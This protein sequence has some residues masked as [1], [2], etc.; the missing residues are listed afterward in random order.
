MFFS[1]DRRSAVSN[2][3]LITS[4]WNFPE[5]CQISLLSTWF[6]PMIFPCF[7]LIFPI[8]FPIFSSIFHHF[9]PS[10]HGSTSPLSWSPG[11]AALHADPAAAAQR[12]RPG[13]AGGGGD[14]ACLGDLKKVELVVYGR[15]TIWLWLRVC[16]GSHHHAKKR[17]VN[18][19]YWLGPSKPWQT[20]K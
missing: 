4:K 13:G 15:F 1:V 3:L 14:A 20:V 5:K 18:H 17:T 7:F 2:Q 16:H 19:L 9:F 10:F 8:Y 11:A 6:S 12:S